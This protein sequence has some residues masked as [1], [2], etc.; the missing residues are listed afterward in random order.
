VGQAQKMAAPRAHTKAATTQKKLSK[1]QKLWMFNMGYGIL[2]RAHAIRA[3]A[4]TRTHIQTCK[5]TRTHARCG[6]AESVHGNAE[7]LDICPPPK[8]KMHPYT[9]HA[10][11]WDSHKY[12]HT[13]TQAVH[14][15]VRTHAHTHTCRGTYRAHTH[16]TSQH[17]HCTPPYTNTY[18]CTYTCTHLHVCTCKHTH[19]TLTRTE[20]HEQPPIYFGS[21]RK[22]NNVGASM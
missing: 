21:A 9:Q 15:R 6:D 1:L 7:S 14:I 17:Y 3:Y 22:E 19:N 2:A 18:T 8:P 5:Y 20:H 4:Y 13:A 11:A 16:S 12:T 10:R